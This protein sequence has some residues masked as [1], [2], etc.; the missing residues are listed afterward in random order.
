MELRKLGNGHWDRKLIARM[1]AKSV[2]DDFDEAIKEWKATGDCWWPK[3][4][5]NDI[6]D[7]VRVSENG[8]GFCLCGHTVYYHFCIINTVTQEQ[9]CVGS[10]H[11]NAY[12]IAR[13]IAE[14]MGL[15]PSDI[16]EE[17]VQMWIKER[18]KNMKAD[19]WWAENGDYWNEIT[20]GL[21]EV[22]AWINSRDT[23]EYRW[24]EELQQNVKKRKLIKRAVGEPLASNYQ[25]ASVFWRWDNPKNSR[26]QINGQG[27]PNDAL[28]RDAT[29]LHL[30]MREPYANAMA[31][32]RRLIETRLERLA[33]ER[34]RVARLREERERQYEEAQRRMRLRQE[35]KRLEQKRN[36]I[37]YST[38]IDN[39]YAKTPQVQKII[40]YYG[41]IVDSLVTRNDNDLE[42]YYFILEHC[43][44]HGEIT[45]PQVRRLRAIYGNPDRAT[46]EQILLIR[47]NTEIRGPITKDRAEELIQQNNGWVA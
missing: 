6:P 25:M 3:Y 40:E 33:E 36:S 44:K 18:V 7:W 4:F 34:E 31:E 19:A 37:G 42:E 15:E 24:D 14:E 12:M 10:D 5:D 45:E 11:I 41:I 20:E 47:E 21:R 43:V 38:S 28:L 22:D 26:A 2:S 35:Q 32:R 13:S 1:L 46:D 23:N 8:P 27:Y 16:S 30:T 17:Q 9:E 29:I 39:E